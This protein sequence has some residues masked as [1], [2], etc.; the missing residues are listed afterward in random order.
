MTEILIEARLLWFADEPDA[1]CEMPSQVRYIEHGVLAIGADGMIAWCGDRSELPEHYRCWPAVDHR[2]NLVMPGFIDTHIH[3]PQAQVVASYAGSLLEWLN[4]Y[5]FVEE[6]RFGDDVH[7]ERIAAAFFDQL[8]AHG[9]TTASAYCSVH[10]Q[11][12]EAFF[13]E[14]E[15]RNLRMAG[16]KVMMDR[17]A[18]A[19]LT[20][21][22]QSGYDDTKALISKWHGC[23]RLSYAI[24]PRFALTSTEAQL[25]ASGAL[26]AEHR[27]CLVQTHIDENHGEIAEAARLFPWARDYLDIYERY[28]L[29]GLSMLLGHCVHLKDRELRRIAETGSV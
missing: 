16:G 13:A 10:R 14:A 9:T 12:A 5:T 29:L 18:P 17:G 27:E 25:E 3:F 24:S 21:T 28:G 4:R 11:S 26:V 2:R 23:G 6:Q 15:R 1:E 8:I 19:A 7:A 22:A 20:D